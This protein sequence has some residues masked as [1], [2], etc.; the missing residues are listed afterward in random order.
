MGP[1]YT[2]KPL[3]FLK[4]L[5]N[6]WGRLNN[7]SSIACLLIFWCN[8]PY[9]GE[10]LVNLTEEPKGGF[11]GFLYNLAHLRQIGKFLEAAFNPPK[12]ASEN[13]P[14]PPH[15]GHCWGPSQESRGEN[16]F[17][18]GCIVF[19]P[20]SVGPEGSF[21]TFR[22]DPVL[23]CWE[24]GGQELLSVFPGQLVGINDSFEETNESPSLFYGF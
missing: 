18:L 1:I 4:F 9:G 14:E 10:Y 21:L 19:Q 12:V 11:W 23:L 16:P 17:Y 2:L 24:E 7:T 15:V 22:L 6:V 13:C 20:S 5:S 8:L 3:Q